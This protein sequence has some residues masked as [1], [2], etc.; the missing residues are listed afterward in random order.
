MAI[1][2]DSPCKN[3]NSKNCLGHLGIHVDCFVLGV[4]SRE[5][6]QGHSLTEEEHNFE[7]VT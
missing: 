1:T 3:H 4:Q 6:A 7:E 5:P 2:S